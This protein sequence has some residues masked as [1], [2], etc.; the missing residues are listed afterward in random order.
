MIKLISLLEEIQ[1]KPKAIFLAGSAGSGKSTIA[2]Q[3]IPS[4]FKFLNIDNI[5]KKLLQ[6]SGIGIKLTQMS[7]DEL[8]K[9]GEF[10]SQARKFIDQKY[11]KA[12]SNLRDILID[13]T[14][15][16][17]K[18]LLNKKQELENMG[19]ETAMLMTYVS[20]I[21]ALNRN[22]ERSR[23]LLPNIVIRSWK[24]ANKNIEIY[25]Q[26]FK[27][28]FML[29]DLDPENTKKDFNEDYIFKTYIKPLGQIGKQKTPEEQIKS[30]KEK[31]QLY[32]DVKQIL[33][34]PPEVDSFRNVTLKTDNFI[35][36]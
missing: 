23:S 28:N 11:Q 29:V 1:R 6:K 20:P 33:N 17:S 30:D 36:K 24:D 5:Y 18:T 31:Q 15:G 25:R 12:T 34:N 4:T 35:N 27:D 32:S 16:S 9:S 14:G 3:I 10:M 2:K 19:Y 22:K 8:K 13:G 7:P 21:T 26:E